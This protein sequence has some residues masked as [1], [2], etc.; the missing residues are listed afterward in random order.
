[1][2]IL[3]VLSRLLG[4]A[5]ALVTPCLDEDCQTAYY[6]IS[7][8]YT[9]LKELYSD[10]NKASNARRELYSL[11]ISLSQ[12]FQEFYAAFL[13]LATKSGLRPEDY[14]YEINEY[15]T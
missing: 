15:L 13:R 10:L 6:T 4:S 12:L 8:L 5:L 1:M 14:K 3:Y 7:E 11:Y 9:H 2:K